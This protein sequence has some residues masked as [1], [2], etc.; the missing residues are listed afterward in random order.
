MAIFCHYL[1]A[2]TYHKFREPFRTKIILMWL[3]FER[4]IVKVNKE[5]V[6]MRKD[7]KKLVKS[8]LKEDRN[9]VELVSKFIEIF[10]P[11]K[12]AKK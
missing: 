3:D 11:K 8:L 12:T 2:Q 1:F 7:L 4:E 5:D 6:G 10:I 9:N